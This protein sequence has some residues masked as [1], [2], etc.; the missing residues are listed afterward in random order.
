MAQPSGQKGQ[1]AFILFF[2][3]TLCVGL[4]AFCLWPKRAFSVQENRVL[5][6]APSF[7]LKA[8]ADGT[9]TKE[10]ENFLADQFP[11]RDSWTSVKST[12][13]KASGQKENNGVYFGRDGYLL[14]KL[15]ATQKE[16]L[17]QNAQALGKFAQKIQKPVYVMP[18][19]SATWVMADWLP[20]FA[21]EPNQQEQQQ[22]F[23][24]M[25]TEQ[26]P[27]VDVF[28]QLRAHAEEGLYYRTD[29]HWNEKGAYWGY[30]QL[31]Q[32]LGYTPMETADF[33]YQTV[34]NGFLGTSY[35]KAKDANAR[36][37]AIVQ[38]TP[39]NR[40]SISMTVLDDGS[41]RESLFWPEKLEEKDQYT[42]YLG[43][44]H[45]AVV[46]HNPQ[47]NGQT[48]LLIKDSYAHILAPYLAAQYSQVHLIDLRYYHAPLSAYVDEQGIDQVAVVCRMQ[49]LNEETSFSVL[50]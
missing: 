3:G 19:P 38:F 4:V 35:S 11:L 31:V 42:Y 46:T 29:H 16:N 21:P 5:Q 41:Q 47:G 44:N 15:E 36:A 9:F 24:Q 10:F 17:R 40:P 50:R 43:G 12:L 22:A 7:N 37:D 8:L 13:Q 49:S 25:L 39:L 34:S 48:L 33:A 32:A 27:L 23:A 1:K 6:Q 28:A 2:I 30:R 14:P 20:A 18:V 26:T 45:A